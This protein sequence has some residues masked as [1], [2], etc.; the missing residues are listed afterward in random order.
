MR[1]NDEKM[2]RGMLCSC[3][4]FMNK[5]EKLRKEIEIKKQESGRFSFLRFLSIVGFIF[6]I[7]QGYYGNH[8]YFYIVSILMCVV[9]IYLVIKHNRIKKK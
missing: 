9:F 5:R 8:P 7:Y 3:L 2:K 1:Y 4:I 6:G